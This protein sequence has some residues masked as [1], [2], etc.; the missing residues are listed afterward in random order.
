MLPSGEHQLK[1]FLI[2]IKEDQKHVAQYFSSVEG[3][4]LSTM[5]YI[6]NKKI[7]QELRRNKDSQ[8][9]EN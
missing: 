7:L 8:K 1:L 4:V 3:K 9:K 5:N 2:C 6:S